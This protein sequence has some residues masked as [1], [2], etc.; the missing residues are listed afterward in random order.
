MNSKILS[1]LFLF[2]SVIVVALYILGVLPETV[3]L[4]V[5]GVLVPGGVASLRAFIQSPGVKTYAVSILILLGTAGYLFW[6]SLVTQEVFTNWLLFWGLISG[7]TL[8]N[9]I[10]KANGK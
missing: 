4:A 2:L 7:V 9:G 6:P 10:A 8:T 1:Y 5:V 3:M